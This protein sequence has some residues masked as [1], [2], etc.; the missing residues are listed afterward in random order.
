[1]PTFVCNTL[2]TTQSI[3][4]SVCDS[5]ASSVA[6]VS[7]VDRVLC[8]VLAVRRPLTVTG[9][10]HHSRGICGELALT[11]KDAVECRSQEW[12]LIPEQERKRLGL[13]FSDD[14]EF[15]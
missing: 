7:A 9:H 6:F 3:A 14:G 10:P 11:L 5:W 2:T 13:V 1:M 8:L 15:W 4:K 12:K